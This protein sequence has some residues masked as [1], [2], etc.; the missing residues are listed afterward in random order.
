MTRDKVLIYL[1]FFYYIGVHMLIMAEPR[2][3]LALVPFLSI[4]A[5]QGAVTIPRVRRR[6]QASD[7]TVRRAAGWRLAWCLLA[8]GLLVL[9]WAYELHVDM[10]KLGMIFSAGGNTARFTY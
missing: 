10:D 5:V 1:L 3:H 6:L 8:M 4:F 2:F 7:A 9:N